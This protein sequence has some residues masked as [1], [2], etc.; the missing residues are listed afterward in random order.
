MSKAKTQEEI[1]KHAEIVRREITSLIEYI[2]NLDLGF[3]K[4]WYHWECTKNF[5]TFVTLQNLVDWFSNELIS[6]LDKK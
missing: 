2:K 1:L 5:I 6:K 4:G 3:F